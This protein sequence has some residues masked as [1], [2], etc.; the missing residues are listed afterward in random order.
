MCPLDTC[1]GRGDIAG[2]GWSRLP[3]FSPAPPMRGGGR[4]VRDDG[5]FGERLGSGSTSGA[6][7]P[8]GGVLGISS[9]PGV[10]TFLAAEAPLPASGSTGGG[11][12]HAT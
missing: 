12:W 2:A 9:R 10:E 5:V 1:H 4:S 3:L 7:A 11:V 6:V 8:L